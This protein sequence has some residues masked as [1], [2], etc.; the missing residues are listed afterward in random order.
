MGKSRSSNSELSSV[1][2]TVESIWVAIVLAFVVRAFMIEAFVIPTGSMAPRLMGEHQDIVCPSCGYEYAY[3]VPRGGGTLSRSARHM[4]PGARCPNC[5]YPFREQTYVNGGDRVLVLKYLYRFRDPRPW[6]VVVFKNPQDARQNYIKRLV[7]LPGEMIEIVHGNIFYRQGFDRNG[8]GR[9]DWRDFDFNGDGILDEADF[10][11]PAALEENP[12]QIRRKDRQAQQ[13]MWQVVFDND[14]RPEDRWLREGHPPRW[15]RTAA[16]D[17]WDLTGND[18]RVFTFAGGPHWQEL[19]FQADPAVFRPHYGYNAIEE[20]RRTI[21]RE[22]DVCYDLRLSFVWM[23]DGPGARVAGMLSNFQH[24]FRIE[25]GADGRARLLRRDLGDPAWDEVW[26]EASGPPLQAGR[27]HQVEMMHVD[28]T[29]QLWV[30][31]REILRTT[32]D[33]YAADYLNLKSRLRRQRGTSLPEPEVRLAAGGAASE[34]RHVQLHRDVY[35]TNAT[36]A[37]VPAG[38]LGRLARERLG[39]TDGK[40]AR[41]AGW[42]TTGHPI[43]LRKQ[44]D[45]DFDEFFVLGDNSPQSLDGR[46]WTAASPSLREG[47]KLG[48]VPRY[49]LIGRALLVYWPAG[50]RIPGLPGLPLIPNVGKM[51]LIY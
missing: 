41:E 46:A 50:Y 21:N 32:P 36:L 1:R 45:R 30:D 26:Q 15:Q 40:P 24:D 18:G 43:I 22:L 23:P 17:D 48:T 27:G 33:Q 16:A 29:V 47:Y 10:L 42:G 44:R 3:G 49:N 8:D 19:R 14:Y 34:L 35:Y 11:S 12:W 39:S 20:E 38:P 7:G 25:L 31:G 13:A 2:D 4:A 9:I 37:P 5:D 6:D 51:R 28:H